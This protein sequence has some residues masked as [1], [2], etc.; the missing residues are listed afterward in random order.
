MKLTMLTILTM[1]TV[2]HIDSL[3]EVFSTA[4]LPARKLIALDQRP[5]YIL[6]ERGWGSGKSMGKSMVRRC[7]D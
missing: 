7:R 2:A 3:Y 4:L 6:L 5:W 1:L